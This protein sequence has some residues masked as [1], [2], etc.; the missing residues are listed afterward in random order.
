MGKV[1]QKVDNLAFF[2]C[3]CVR[4]SVCVASE[5]QLKD[6]SSCFFITPT[7]IKIHLCVTVSLCL[8]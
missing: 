1:E 4:M 7:L 2:L 5:R 3:V 6:F 8:R